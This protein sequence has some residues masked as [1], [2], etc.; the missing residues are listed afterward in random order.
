[1][2]IGM[3]GNLVIIKH[4][5]LIICMGTVQFKVN[6]TFLFKSVTVCVEDVFEIL[7]DF[8]LPRMQYLY[9]TFRMEILGYYKNIVE[10]KEK[11]LFIF[12]CECIT[13]NKC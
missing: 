8:C 5:G 11:F 7:A 10:P 13:A 3:E 2:F 12:K 1:M 9:M 4:L 6:Q